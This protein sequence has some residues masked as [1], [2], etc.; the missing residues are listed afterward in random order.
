M[1]EGPIE[2][3]PCDGIEEGG[4]CDDSNACTVGEACVSGFCVGGE[5]L[6]CPSADGPCAISECDPVQ[7]CLEGLK[8]DD[9]PCTPL[10]HTSGRCIAGDCIP[11]AGTETVCPA[12]DDPC[13]AAVGCDAATGECTVPIYA[14]ACPEGSV[15]VASPALE[16]VPTF[17]TTCMPCDEDAD[18]AD[19]AFPDQPQACASTGNDG[20]FC[21][22]GCGDLPC[23]P[24]F[25]CIDGLC[26]KTEGECTCD[27]SWAAMGLTTACQKV[28]EHG[29]CLGQRGCVPGGL[30]ACDAKVPAAEICNGV[31]DDC[32]GLVDEPA[33][34]CGVEGACCVDG[35]CKLVYSASCDILGGV[36]NGADTT[37]AT[38]ACVPGIEAACCVSAQQCAPQTVEECVDANGVYKGDGK[39]CVDVDC[40]APVETVACCAA[41]GACS[42][43]DV[44]GCAV[45]GAVSQGS[46][47]SC[48][49][50]ACPPLGSCC[51][52]GG[53]CGVT[54]KAPCTALGGAWTGNVGCDDI[55]CLLGGDQGACCLEGGACTVTDEA[56][57][58]D[59]FGG[60]FLTGEQCM[61]QCPTPTTAACCS[62]GECTMVGEADCDGD[63]QGAGTSCADACVETE[64]A[65]CTEGLCFQFTQAQ[66]EI[67]GGEYKGDEVPCAGACVAR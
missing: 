5:A 33:G 31:D 41:A 45:S 15:C 25:E 26:L 8:A 36:F 64:G 59:D 56:G 40:S 9:S 66:C 23:P 53:A 62:N 67:V 21:A 19:P 57:C 18:C 6:E 29:V 27:P 28:N 38:S 61:G 63:F 51:Y 2:P 39:A 42:N 13:L 24:G 20:S 54:E 48:L 34:A 44:I 65:C 55:A 49:N 12:P 7:G 32:D 14:L 60:L 1:D 11:E 43:K 30:T 10:C 47:T 37:C 16:C 3:G 52:P 35:E 50:T 17:T 46:G 22:G 58:E 4:A